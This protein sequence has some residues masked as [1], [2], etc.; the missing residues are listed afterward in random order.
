VAFS[1]TLRR[2]PTPLPRRSSGTNARPASTAAFG[3]RI[4]ACDPLIR[5]SPAAFSRPKK[6]SDDIL[7][8]RPNEASQPNDF[9]PAD[10]EREVTELSRRGQ[11]LDGQNRLTELDAP[12]RK[13]LLDVARNHQ[14][15]DRVSRSRAGIDDCYILAVAKHGYAVAK[16]LD[17]CEIVRDIDDGDSLASEPTDQR[18]KDLGFPGDERSGRFVEHQRRGAMKQ[19]AGYLDDLFLS[20]GEFADQ[21]PRAQSKPKIIPQNVRGLVT[22]RAAIDQCGKGS[23]PWLAAEEQR[24]AHSETRRE[25]PVLMD[26][27]DAE[28][29][30]LRRRQPVDGL[31]VDQDFAGVG[32]VKPGQNLD[33]S[34]FPRTVLA[35]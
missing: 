10:R 18:E 35:D 8:A 22:H 7:C 28:A 16:V 25:Q 30:R 4:E 34:R 23:Q 33:K 27:M 5:I 12:L 19:R 31:P 3:E 13:K 21:N 24:F 26:E 1:R 14:R 20:G 2:N 6:R 32:S 15:G 9:A 17:L 29:L 11:S